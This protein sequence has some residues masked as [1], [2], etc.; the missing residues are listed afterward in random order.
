MPET[1]SVIF[2]NRLLA[3][4][5]QTDSDFLLNEQTDYE[6][7]YDRAYER[8]N[9]ASPH[10]CGVQSHKTEQP[11]SEYAAYDTDNEIDNEARTGA[12]N[13]KAAE[14]SR[15]KSYKNIP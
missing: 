1:T 9:E 11:S 5:V 14:I 8:R 2:L 12:F 3:N 6:Q 15:G 13:D 10:T 4:K 7:K